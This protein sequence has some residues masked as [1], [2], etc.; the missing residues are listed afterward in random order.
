[1]VNQA[2]MTVAGLG[3]RLL[4]LSAATP[5]ELLPL[6]SKPALQWIA[7]ELCQ[8]GINHLSLVTSPRKSK[9]TALFDLDRQLEGSLNQAG[10]SEALAQLWSRGPHAGT[11][12]SVSLQEQQLGLGHAVLCGA[13]ALEPQPFVLALGDALIRPLGSS[14]LVNELIRVFEQE[15]AEAV[16]AFREVDATAVSR[17]GIAAPASEGDV[18]RLDDLVEKPSPANAPS[19]LAIAARY[20]F[21]ETIFDYLRQT[22]PGHGGEIQLTDAVRQMLRDGRRVFGVRLAADESRI[23]IGNYPE[24]AWAFIEQAI[25]EDPE[26][27]I[28]LRQRWAGEP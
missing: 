19:R 10:N 14:R 17:Y 1:M 2:L 18:F 26:L 23:D 5:K 6:G 11:R 20:V 21:R 4:P 28:R 25:A 16:I 15:Q 22:P 12:I 8:A 13:Q 3:T 24:F 27:E 9:I 7:E